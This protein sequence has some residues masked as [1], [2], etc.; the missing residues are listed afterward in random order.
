VKNKAAQELGKKGGQ[1]TKKK[2]GK[3]H[4]QTIGR[5]AAKARWGKDKPKGLAI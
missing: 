1:K 3:K 4:F 5:L 2:Y